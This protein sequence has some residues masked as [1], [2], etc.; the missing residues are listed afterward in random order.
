M[1]FF[2]WGGRNIPRGGKW[3]LGGGKRGA[4]GREAGI[5]GEAGVGDPPVHPHIG[6]LLFF[7]TVYLCC[8]LMASHLVSRRNFNIK[9]WKI[10]C[11]KNRTLR[12]LYDILFSYVLAVFLFLL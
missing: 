12:T 7:L 4:M 9:N 8:L 6:R 5:R 1:F 10:R 2:R 3:G 11:D